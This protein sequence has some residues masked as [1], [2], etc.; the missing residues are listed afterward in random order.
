MHS[1]GLLRGVLHVDLD[2]VQLVE[3]VALERDGR[4]LHRYETI[5][6][7]LIVFV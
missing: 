4:R 7:D 5:G 3:L 2:D 1:L 6:A